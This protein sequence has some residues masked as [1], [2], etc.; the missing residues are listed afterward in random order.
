[1]TSPEIFVA[2]E[3]ATP[4]TKLCTTGLHS[5]LHQLTI[6]C[7][8]MAIAIKR[9][10]SSIPSAT[11]RCKRP[12]LTSTSMACV[13]TLTAPVPLSHGSAHVGISTALRALPTIELEVRPTVRCVLAACLLHA[14]YCSGCRMLQGL[15]LL[16]AGCCTLL[17]V[18]KSYV[19][20]QAQQQ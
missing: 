11:A 2:A 18:N 5:H 14:S 7:S 3:S 8:I 16:Y 20:T 13:R 10:G 4:T 6:T 15:L 17:P 1:M 19:H 9:R 12:L